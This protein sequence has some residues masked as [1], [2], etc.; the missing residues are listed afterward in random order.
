MSF[1]ILLKHI[2]IDLY[3]FY[4]KYDKTKY[5]YTV[6]KKKSKTYSCHVL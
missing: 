1:E 5:I 4:I 2:Y 3:V 6:K